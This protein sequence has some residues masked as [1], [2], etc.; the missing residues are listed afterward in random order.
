LQGTVDLLTLKTLALGRTNGWSVAQRIQQVLRD[1]LQVQQ[2]SLYP[3]LYGIE[4]KKWIR[5]EWRA[6]ES[7]R[8]AKYYSLTKQTG[9]S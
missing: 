7:N 3:A 1:V 4:R 2:G 9:T 6:S 5:S 8:R